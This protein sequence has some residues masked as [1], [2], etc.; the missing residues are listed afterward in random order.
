M[1]TNYQAFFST[2]ELQYKSREEVI[3]SLEFSSRL[4]SSDCKSPFIWKKRQEANEALGR[5]SDAQC[6]QEETEGK[7]RE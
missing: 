5:G 6:L 3:C 2:T 1:K 7:I 4:Y